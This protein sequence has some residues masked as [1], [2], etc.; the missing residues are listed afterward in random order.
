MCGKLGLPNSWG[1]GEVNFYPYIKGGGA[2]N[3]VNMLMGGGGGHN[4]F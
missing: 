3:V 4:K 2:E 1:I